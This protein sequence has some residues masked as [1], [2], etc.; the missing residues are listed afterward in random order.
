MPKTPIKRTGVITPLVLITIFLF[1]IVFSASASA[2][3]L[4]DINND[5]VININDVLLVRK[6]VSGFD[7]QLTDAQKLVADV[8][9][10]GAINVI[11]VNL[12]MQMSLG[13]I[14]EFPILNKPTLASPA[15]SAVVGGASISFQWAASSGAKRYQLE[16]IR[17]SDSSVFKTEVLGNVTSSTQA[18]FPNDGSL[19][20]WRVRAGNEVAWGTWTAYRNLINGTV[21]V[22]PVLIS[23]ADKANA[24]NATITF[25]W[26]LAAGADKYEL[27]IRKASDDSLFKTVT[28]G[29]ASASMQSGF[30]QDGTQYKWRVRAGNKLGWGAWS[31]YWVFNNGVL[32]A[33]PV[34]SSPAN[35]ANVGGASINFQ[36]AASSGA[37]KY[38]LEILRASDSMVFKNEVVGNTTSSI[39]DNF[40]NDGTLYWWRVRAGND[41]GWGAWSGQMTLT[42]GQPIAAPVLISPADNANTHR[43]SV[44]FEWKPTNGA[45][46]YELRIINIDDSVYNTVSLGN[47]TASIQHDLPNN[48]HYRW[49][50][51]GGNDAK[52]GEWSKTR[53][54]VVG[55]L[56]FAPGQISPADKATVGGISIE[57]KWAAS[58]GADYYELEVVRAR[59]G[60]VFGSKDDLI[61]TTYTMPGF[62]DDGTQYKW[63]VRAG[64][65]IGS[66]DTVGWG[67]WSGYRDFINDTPEND[68][69][70]APKLTSPAN[71]SLV[72]NELIYEE[73]NEV[74]YQVGSE[75]TFKW[76]KITSANKYEIEVIKASDGT[77]F[78]NQVLGDVSIET[79]TDFPNDGTEYMWRVRAGNGADW[80]TWSFYSTFTNGFWWLNL[81]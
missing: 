22:A 11:D 37:K 10:D 57:F 36:W 72:A 25:E 2:A 40:P 79:Y 12:L 46:K 75:I 19:F 43:T 69:L 71:D 63:R 68:N 64:I 77:V 53:N 3:M 78:K 73:V 39:Q 60:A 41:S 56:L 51:R 13:L 29:N 52:W 62:S 58:S 33:A 76:E 49:Q 14:D 34:L 7:P 20:K 74:F 6:H 47:A 67:A 4:G 17:I 32:P 31:D 59:D 23:P 65:K 16:V 45:I 1:L 70:A 80:G 21:P 55:N 81:F 42:N 27:E 15:D 18:G 9:G 28:L 66:G 54:L 48:A 30:P 24:I 35:N 8:N 38:Q 50:V 26:N 61:V 44:M 5:G